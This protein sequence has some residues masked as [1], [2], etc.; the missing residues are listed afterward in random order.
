[1]YRYENG[2]EEH[3]LELWN[4]DG[5]VFPFFNKYT[6]CMLAKKCRYIKNC[7]FSRVSDG[8]TH[9]ALLKPFSCVKCK[10]KNSE[11]DFSFAN[12]KPV[13]KVKKATVL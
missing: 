3:C 12:A 11:K 6:V 1:M 2:E 7:N 10:D 8:T 4:R 9:P 13:L 5:K